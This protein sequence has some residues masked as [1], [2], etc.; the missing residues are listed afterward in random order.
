ME[1]K[2]QKNIMIKLKPENEKEQKINEK[3]K[4][5]DRRKKEEEIK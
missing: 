5:Y 3:A 1:K 2:V 4:I